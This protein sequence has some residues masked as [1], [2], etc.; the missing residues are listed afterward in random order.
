MCVDKYISKGKQMPLMHCQSCHHEWE[1]TMPESLCEWCGKAG[2]A[3]KNKTE[4]EEI[5]SVEK[6]LCRSK[7]NILMQNR[8]K[9]NNN[10]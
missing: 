7:L 2:Y 3:L 6:G 9:M 1:S 10:H 5:L 8:K 4:L